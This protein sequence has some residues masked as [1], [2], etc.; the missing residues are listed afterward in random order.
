MN[1][2]ERRIRKAEPADV[3]LIFAFDLESTK[4]ERRGFIQRAVDNGNAHVLEQDAKIIAVGILEYA[5]FE[6]GFISLIYV[7]PRELRTG[8]GEMLVRCL[9]SA[10]HTS[11]L[12]SSTNLTNLPMHALFAKLGFEMS[13]IVHNLDPKDP[14]VIYCKALDSDV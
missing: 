11:K 14:E 8:A 7:D 5:F 6:Y 9:I 1:L 12:F 2:S 10:C 4:Y 13:G 3:N